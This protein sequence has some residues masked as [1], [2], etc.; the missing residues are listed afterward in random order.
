MGPQNGELCIHDGNYRQHFAPLINGEWKSHGLV[1]RDYALYPRGCY[2]SIQ[3]VDVPLI[4]RSEWSAR[5]KEM[6]A[7]KSRLSDLRATEGPSSGLIPSLDQNGKG[8]C[9]AHSGVSATLMLRAVMN[10]PYVSLSAYAVACTIKSYRDEGGWGAQGVDFLAS[11]G[12]PSDQFWPQ[13]SM[14]PSN[15]KPA[16]WENAALHKVTGQWADLAAQEYDR[17]LSFDQV[18]SLL[19]ARVPVVVDYNWW[20][21][22]V[23]AIDPVEVS[24]GSFGV[25]IL[26]SWGDSWSDRG[27][28][29]LE[30]NK[31][32]PDGAVAPLIT[33]PSVV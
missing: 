25:R 20:S 23:C 3:A 26:N 33:L 29:V 32:I 31:A 10:E 30:G 4:P 22:S 7:T 2:A 15:D 12:V 13:R 27:M 19:L 1:P 24:A 11:R 5:I 18:M 8:Y 16:T 17:K 9:W 14:S 21:H 28:G 6:E